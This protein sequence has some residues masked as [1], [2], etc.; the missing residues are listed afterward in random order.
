MLYEEFLTHA[1]LNDSTK[2][3]EAYQTVENIYM[4]TGEEFE[5]EDAYRIGRLA[6]QSELLHSTILKIADSMQ[7]LKELSEPDPITP[8]LFTIN[9]YNQRTGQKCAVYTGVVM[10][11][12]EQ[13]AKQMVYE[14][15]DVEKCTCLNLYEV[16]DFEEVTFRPGMF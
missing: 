5:K 15:H 1:K 6:Y 13:E 16:E 7:K 4:A 11:E 2:A 9:E 12:T 10:S 8:Y 14:A 3:F